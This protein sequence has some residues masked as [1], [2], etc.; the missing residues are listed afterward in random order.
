MQKAQAAQFQST[1]PAWGA[2]TARRAMWRWRRFQSTLP[3]W[4][5]TY[6]VCKGSRASKFQSTLPAW[7]ATVRHREH[8]HHLIISIHAPRVGSDVGI[9]ACAAMGGGF[10]STLPAW[11]AT[12]L[13]RVTAGG[14]VFQ[15]TLPAWGAT[16]VGHRLKCYYKFQSTL[17]AW[18][19]TYRR[20]QD[21]AQG[22]ISI[23][24]PRVG[25]DTII[26]SMIDRLLISIH[27]P[28]VGSD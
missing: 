27:A 28:R 2:T 1:L 4:G 26:M 24:A 17:P 23:H 13:I 15:S 16:G 12:A 22:E 11:G 9:A 19:A 25:S 6:V 10:Q 7:G 14:E 21:D 5:A 8:L 3:A 20:P 18:G